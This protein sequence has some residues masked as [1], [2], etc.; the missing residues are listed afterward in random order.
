MKKEARAKKQ[1]FFEKQQFFAPFAKY[2]RPLRLKLR[3]KELMP[4]TKLKL[5][6]REEKIEKRL[7]IK[8][9]RSRKQDL[10]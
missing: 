8:E 3:R 7:R 5:E 6:N 4:E 2:W 10:Y 9:S 1:D